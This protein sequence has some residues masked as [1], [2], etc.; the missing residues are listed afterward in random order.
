[1]H[2]RSA[3]ALGLALAFLS[4]V[5]TPAQVA[6]AAVQ[7]QARALGS[8]TW[9]GGGKAA[10]FGGFSGIVVQDRGQRLTVISDRGRIATGRI[11]R[12][13]GRIGGVAL[14]PLLPLRDTRGKPVT[15]AKADAEGL[16]IRPDGRLF[17]SFEGY[18]RVWTYARVGGEAAWLPRAEAF[19]SLNNNSS[20]E[21]LAIDGRGWLYTIPE[22]SPGAGKPF[23]VYR[24]RNG[25]WDQPFSIPRRGRYLMTDAD[26]GPDGRLYVLER[27]LTIINGFSS[28]VRRFDLSP[29]GLTQE[30]TL[31]TTPYGMYDNLEGISVWQ[32][33]EGLR[34][35]MVSDDNFRFFQKTELVEYGLPLELRSDRR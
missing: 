19:K 34:M 24:Y 22:V 15:G 6:G 8:F 17:I 20:L 9:N 5:Q 2:R 4:V 7:Q 31:L 32:A 11:T 10:G 16:A 14:D 29:D 30:V 26:V 35:T 23:P 12:H 18:A 33:P 1:M 21:A 13:N 25:T 28:R 27:D 3:L